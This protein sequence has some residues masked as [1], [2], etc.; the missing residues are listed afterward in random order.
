MKRKMSV[1]KRRELERIVGA[2]LENNYGPFTRTTKGGRGRLWLSY[3]LPATSCGIG[4]KLRHIKGSVCSLCYARKGTYLYPMPTAAMRRR[5]LS[6]SHPLWMRSMITLLHG[7]EFFRWHDSGDIQSL[8]HLQNIVEVARSL[9]DTKFWLPTKEGGILSRFLRNSGV[10]KNLAIRLSATMIDA[11]P[12]KWYKLTSTV[13]TTGH[14][15]GFECPCLAEEEA[16][17]GD[18]RVCWDILVPNISYP[19]H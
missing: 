7:K 13:H 9:P 3:S 14:G 11:K 15:F 17:C 19:L 4:S 2:K 16:S 1:E 18:C 5:L 6:L 12:P 10:P 8:Q